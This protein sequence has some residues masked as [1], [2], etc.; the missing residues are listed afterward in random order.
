ML[1]TDQPP[2]RKGKEGEVGRRSHASGLK[3]IGVHGVGLGILLQ[4][5]K[6]ILKVDD[7]GVG[8]RMN[9]MLDAR[10]VAVAVAV[11]AKDGL[12]RGSLDG[13]LGGADVL[14]LEIGVAVF[15]ADGVD[16]TVSVD[17]DIVVVERRP[18][19]YPTISATILLTRMCREWFGSKVAPKSSRD[20]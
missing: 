18:R 17:V 7:M 10:V 14:L 20:S 11:L 3:R 4:G 6:L 16:G 9:L 5:K 13:K 12:P 8:G 2:A 15:D 19:P 1:V